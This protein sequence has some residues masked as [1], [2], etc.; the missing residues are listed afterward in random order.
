MEKSM[1]LGTVVLTF[2]QKNPHNDK[3]YQNVGQ[4][5]CKP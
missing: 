4:F 2:T 3:K 1:F 5:M